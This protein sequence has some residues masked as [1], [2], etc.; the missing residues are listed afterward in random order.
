MIV[1][2]ITKSP[3]LFLIIFA[4]LIIW[5]LYD[6]KKYNESKANDQNG[7]EKK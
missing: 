4:A 1:G 7:E 5:K 6:K 3:I 2:G